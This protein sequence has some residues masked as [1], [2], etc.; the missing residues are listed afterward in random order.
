MR[1]GFI[2]ESGFGENVWKPKEKL[3]AVAI[4]EKFSLFFFGQRGVART[5]YLVENRIDAGLIG[6]LL[7]VI[8][9][10]GIAVWSVVVRMMIGV[11]VVAVVLVA[12]SEKRAEHI[13]QTSP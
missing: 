4:V 9:V 6:A 5:S 12:V 2:G 1:R 7:C 11:A 13:F 3:S 10:V 8:L